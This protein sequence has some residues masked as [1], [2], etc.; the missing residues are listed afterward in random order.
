MVEALTRQLKRI[1]PDIEIISQQW[2]KLN[3]SDY[4][5]F[6]KAHKTAAPDAVFSVICCGNFNLFGKQASAEG[7]FGMLGGKFIGVGETGS[8]EYIDP[9]MLMD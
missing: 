4:T 1:R 3:E 8:A 7:Y 9:K 2:P 5:P 6:I